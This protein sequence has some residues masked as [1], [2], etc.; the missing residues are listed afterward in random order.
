MQSDSHYLK[1]RFS[2]N[3]LED[4]SVIEKIIN[5][6]N[7]EKNDHLIEIGPGKGALTVPI[8]KFV[9]KIDVIEIDKQL[10]KLLKDNIDDKKL[11]IHEYDALKFD[12]SKFKNR[13]LRLIGNL[14]YNISTPLLFYLLSYKNI[15]KNMFQR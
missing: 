6:I 1:K 12:Y 7:P 11:T 5:I 3:F 15:I 8:I 9:K 10:V 13:N 4:K 2:Q 14:P